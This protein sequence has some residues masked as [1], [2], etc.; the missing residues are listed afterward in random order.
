MNILFVCTGNTCRS[1]MAEGYLNHKYKQHTAKSCG[2]CAT[3]SPVSQNSKQVMEEIGVDISTHVSAP[4]TKELLAWAEKIICMSP[5]HKEVL[6]SIGVK[7]EVL[8]N[9]I[10]DPFG[11]DI[12]TYRKCRD[13]IAKE[14]DQLFEEFEVVAIEYKHLKEIAMLE[15]VCF[16]TPW[17]EQSLCDAHKTGTR[18]FVATNGKK[19]LGYVGIS[20]ILDEGYI[21]NIAVFPEYRNKGVATALL[22]KLFSLASEKN[23]SF[24]SLEVRESNHS[25][26]S[27]YEKMGFL[28]EGKRK[29]F[30]TLPTEDALILT[31]RFD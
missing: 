1:P 2:L 18:F 21:T 15:K 9:G 14:I 19:V 10:A 31:K 26:I 28:Q 7:A 27:L 16:S 25:A 22:L 5:S 4:L 11:C 13:Q 17:S 8:G 24:I 29:N 20:V 23:L 6:E 30:Y 12:S 3:A